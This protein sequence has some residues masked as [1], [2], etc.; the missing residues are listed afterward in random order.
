MLTYQKV[1]DVWQNNGAVVAKL[2]SWLRNKESS[3]QDGEPRAPC[4]T[5]YRKVTFCL[6]SCGETGESLT[7]QTSYFRDYDIDVKSEG[8]TRCSP[9]DYMDWEKDEKKEEENEV[10]HV[11]QPMK[12]IIELLQ[13]VLGETV[14][15]VTS[16]FFIWLC[17]FFPNESNLNE[18]HRLNFKDA[19]KN[20]QPSLTSAQ[21]A[22]SEFH[23]YLQTATK[24]QKLMSKW[25]VISTF[26]PSIPEL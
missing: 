24:V 16:H 2:F 21:A 20:M 3:V 17:Y 6:P 14:P 10:S 11:V 18:A 23:N 15:P 19:I 1:I 4:S 9:K 7:I 8:F 22:I 25:G 12:A 26:S 13:K 5:G